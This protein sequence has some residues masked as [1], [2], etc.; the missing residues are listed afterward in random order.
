MGSLAV[1]VDACRDFEARRPQAFTYLES[2]AVRAR[3]APWA[4]TGRGGM[5]TRG[6]D[7]P[8]AAREIYQSSAPPVLFPKRFPPKSPHPR[9]FIA[10]RARLPITR[11]SP[12]RLPFRL[13]APCTPIDLQCSLDP[14]SFTPPRSLPAHLP[15]C[16]SPEADSSS[17]L[18]PPPPLPS[19]LICRV[20][21]SVA[22]QVWEVD[23]V[24]VL[25][26]RFPFLAFCL[27][28][29]IYST[30]NIPP[31]YHPVSIYPR[32]FVLNRPGIRFAN[33]LHAGWFAS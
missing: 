27:F 2:R 25:P 19:P 6:Y 21:R 1:R 18:P 8:P 4:W 5:G 16:S 26:S 12:A 17:V 24:A 13:Q 23:S 30:Y 22:L 15:A 3:L 9:L 31:V 11:T 32:F 28:V 33:D 29:T 14:T 7:P 20:H 10:A